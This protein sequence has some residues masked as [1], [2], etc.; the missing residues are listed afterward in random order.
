[1]TTNLRDDTISTE[2][3][4]MSREN[5]ELKDL[6]EFYP[7]EQVELLLNNKNKLTKVAKQFNCDVPY[8]SKSTM[9]MICNSAKC[10]YKDIC[11]L[12]KNQL[13]PSGYPCPIEKKIINELESSIISELDIDRGSTLE[14]ELLFDLID[15]KLLDMRTSGLIGKASVVHTIEIRSGNTV[16]TTKD[17]APEFKVKMDLKKLKFSIMEEFMATRKAR[18]KYGIGGNDKQFEN[19]IRSAMNKEEE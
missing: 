5:S 16:T 18:K 15:A 10:P 2:I 6:L 1:M 7:E 4:L 9:V 19:L 12:N 8:I 3:A 17:I 11:I 14:M 13:A